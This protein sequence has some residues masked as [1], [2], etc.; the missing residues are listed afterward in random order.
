MV[1]Y[2]EHKGR[3]WLICSVLHNYLSTKKEDTEVIKWDTEVCFSNWK[4]NNNLVLPHVNVL[5]FLLLR[6]WPTV[7]R[8]V[9]HVG[10]I[11]YV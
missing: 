5:I 6:T 10:S 7:S 3:I 4:R 8:V 1:L 2:I 11:F 9:A